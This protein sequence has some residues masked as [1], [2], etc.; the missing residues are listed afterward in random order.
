M[1]TPARSPI[2]LASQMDHVTD[3]CTN[4]QDKR[5]LTAKAPAPDQAVGGDRDE[6]SA[7]TS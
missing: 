2:A 3:L 4:K 6:Q 7:R 5:T 1:E